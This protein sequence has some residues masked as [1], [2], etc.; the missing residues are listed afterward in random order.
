[1]LVRGRDAADPRSTYANVPGARS[2]SLTVSVIATATSTALDA[3][4]PT[5]KVS[6]DV[7]TARIASPARASGRERVTC[8]TASR[9]K[10]T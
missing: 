6:G 8:P 9:A 1:M 4:I 10:I 5:I 3:A 2:P 7:T